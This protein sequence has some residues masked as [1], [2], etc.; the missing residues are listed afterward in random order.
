MPSFSPDFLNHLS[1]PPHLVRTIRAIGEHKGRQ[2]LYRLQAPEKLENLRQVAVIQSV[3]SSN[4]IEGVTAPPE[5]LKALLAE[6]TTPQDRSEGEIAGYRDVLATIHGAAMDIPFTDAVV[7]QLHRDLMKYSTQPGGAWKAAPNEIEEVRP[8][9]TR[10]IRFD[11]TAPHLTPTAMAD[12][13]REFAAALKSGEHDPLILVPL[14]VLDFLCI[15][16]FTD[17]NGR[18]ARL[19]SALALYQQG[20][21]VARY[22]SL[23]RL[24]ETTKEGYYDTLYR[25]SQGWHEDGHDPMP[26]IDYWLGILL[27]AYREMESRVGELTTDQGT[28]ADI[29]VAAVDRMLGDFSISELQAA[30]PS[31]SRIW[32]KNV[33]DELKRDGRLEV[34]GRGR[35]SK[36]RK[37]LE[38]HSERHNGI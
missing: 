2:D 23:E 1:V 32:I 21:D 20:Y 26:W 10:F 8:D 19:L 3:E 5:R 27:G 9:G 15:H 30:C 29:V 37:V 16:P 18:M 28:K 38:Q 14:Y 31:V 33:L 7:L 6:K 25:A 36:W 24:I 12:L 34:V 35:G 22:I 17:G 13:H 11:P 4:R